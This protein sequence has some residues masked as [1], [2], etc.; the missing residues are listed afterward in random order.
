MRLLKDT[1]PTI[2]GVG[3]VI[4]YTAFLASSHNH[5]LLDPITNSPAGEWAP[6]VNPVLTEQ[7]T[8]VPKLYRA[9]MDGGMT[10]F[11][12]PGSLVDS[13]SCVPTP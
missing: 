13:L 1:W 12:A 6:V 4:G 3:V 5:K 10:C 11:L 9:E 2:L 8:Y 7:K